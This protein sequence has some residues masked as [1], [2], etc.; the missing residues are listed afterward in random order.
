MEALLSGPSF[1]DGVYN[2]TGPSTHSLA[3]T[4]QAADRL[5]AFLAEQLQLTIRRPGMMNPLFVSEVF[6]FSC[7]VI[8]DPA[9]SK[10]SDFGIRTG[11]LKSDRDSGLKEF[12][13]FES[14]SIRDQIKKN[15]QVFDRSW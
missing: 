12:V 10:T 14:F 1:A 7:K 11:R 5:H 15:L 3:L 8:F 6:T 4:Q 9:S 2:G 13:F